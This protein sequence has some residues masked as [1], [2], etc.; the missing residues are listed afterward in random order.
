MECGPDNCPLGV[1]LSPAERR[2]QGKTSAEKLYAQNF[3]MQ[4]IANLL[5]VSEPTIHRDL[6]SFTMKESKPTEPDQPPP[7]RAKTTTN[8][9]GAGRP[10]GS[11]Q[12]ARKKKAKKSQSVSRPTLG[13]GGTEYIQTW[14]VR[15]DHAIDAC[16]HAVKVNVERALIAKGG[17][18]APASVTAE[19][20]REVF[21]RVREAI[22]EMARARGI[23]EQVRRAGTAAPDMLLVVPAKT[24]SAA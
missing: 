22:D 9:K 3:S 7:K 19:H 11:K 14:A 18:H 1:T 5:G 24:G 6:N 12:P 8:P 13:A 23:D 4:D 17:L 16:V 20:Q 15:P 2:A 21:R 10:K